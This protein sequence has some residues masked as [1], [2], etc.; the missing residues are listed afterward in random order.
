M[1][2]QITENVR[3]EWCGREDLKGENPVDQMST[4]ERDARKGFRGG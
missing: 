1:N 2:L 3:V 4:S